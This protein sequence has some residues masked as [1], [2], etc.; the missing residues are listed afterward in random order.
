MVD[1][2]HAMLRVE[3]ER[4]VDVLERW[5]LVRLE[6]VAL[7]RA[8]EK[9]AVDAEEHVALAGCPRSGAPSSDL[10]RVAGLEDPQRQAALRFEGL[11][12]VVRD[13]E[14]VVRDEHDLA[15]RLVALPL[16]PAE[17]N[18]YERRRRA[19]CAQAAQAISRLRPR[20]TA[21]RTP[22]RALM[23]AV[24]RRRR[25]RLHGSSRARAS[26]PRADTRAAR[27]VRLP[28]GRAARAVRSALRACPRARARR[29]RRARGPGRRARRSAAAR[30]AAS[31]G[32]AASR[33]G[34][35]ACRRRR[36]APGC[37]RV[38]GRPRGRARA[39]GRWR[40]SRPD[41]VRSRVPAVSAARDGLRRRRVEVAHGDVDREAERERVLEALVRGDH[42][43]IR[44]DASARSRR[45]VG[46][47]CHHHH[48]FVRHALPPLALPR[49][50]SAGRRRA[51]PPSQPG[52]P[53]SPL[54]SAHSSGEQLRGSF[55]A[56]VG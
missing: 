11:L 48:D 24:V 53:S 38:E 40:P 20:A 9:I 41:V 32:A 44:R 14:R 36:R 29:A 55:E 5:R 16:Q 19:P 43:R 47:P 28:P 54:R 31:R 18:R 15:R 13:R 17:R 4:R 23:R 56:C 30:S 2:R 34:G 25:S 10:P 22:R 1:R 27:F 35:R 51:H 3:P 37:A 8:G 33:G 45:Q 46:S 42:A 26:R 21:R 50:G 6:H 52:C 39:R 12:H 49:S 7:E